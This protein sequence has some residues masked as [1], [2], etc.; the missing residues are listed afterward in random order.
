MSDETPT[1]GPVTP[2]EDKGPA[3]NGGIPW[4]DVVRNSLLVIVFFAMLWL[5][6][7]VRLPSAEVLRGD[8]DRWGG[9]AWAVFVLF[10]AVLAITPIP[11]SVLATTGGLFFGVVEGSFLSVIGAMLGSWAAYWLAR[12][13]GKTT[14]IKLLGSHA[15]LVQERLA[16]AGASGTYLLRL[17][18]GLPYWV[19][20]YGSG[21][22]GVSQRAFLVGSL[23]GAIPGQVSLVAIGAFIAEPGV[24]NGVVVAV[25]WI[26]VAVLTFFAFRELHRTRKASNA[27]KASGAAHT[28]SATP[29]TS[30]AQT[31]SATP[32]ADVEHPEQPER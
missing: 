28:A 1:A 2:V 18:P 19:V 14:V 13:L 20:N 12:G 17:T 8:L 6:F 3:R 29:A 4:G 22:F 27:A 16:E 24:G 5:A 11:V 30:T 21:A 9:W 31:G 32:T 25:A 10:Y 26:V 23:L 15:D 7:H